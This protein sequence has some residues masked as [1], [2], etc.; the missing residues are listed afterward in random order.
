MDALAGTWDGG[1]GPLLIC[2]CGSLGCTTRNSGLILGPDHH[3][4][5][6][7][8]D[9]FALP[10]EMFNDKHFV[11]FPNVGELWRLTIY[12]PRNEHPTSRQG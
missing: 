4:T 10:V 3:V 9:I 6:E 11:Q 12:S 8:G 7:I 1:I 5:R 2:P